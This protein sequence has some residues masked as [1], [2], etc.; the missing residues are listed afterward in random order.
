MSDCAEI[1][2][3]IYGKAIDDVAKKGQS[4]IDEKDAEL[5]ALLTKAERLAKALEF[6]AKSE[7]HIPQDLGGL[8]L[9]IQEDNCGDLARQA[10]A[11]W[12]GE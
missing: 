10:L 2:R 8:T 12:R 9:V 6:Y 3:K 7:V 4:I 5:S 1:A 11:E